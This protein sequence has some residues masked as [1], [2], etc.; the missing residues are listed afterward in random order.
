MNIEKVLENLNQSQNQALNRLFELI[1]IPS[2]STDTKHT[3]DCRKAAQWLVDDLS[4]MGFDSSLRET[5]GHP[6]VLASR[7]VVS[8]FVS[9][10]STINDF[11]IADVP[12]VQNLIGF[13]GDYL[14]KMTSPLAD[15]VVNNENNDFN[16]VIKNIINKRK[17]VYN[18]IPNKVECD[19][20][21]KVFL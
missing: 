7:S 16:L 2:I 1:R 9:N 8:V 17:N 11:Y 5:S 10:T 6:M 20:D 12:I 13:S 4:E 15:F 18:N 3:E 14:E 21:F 19:F